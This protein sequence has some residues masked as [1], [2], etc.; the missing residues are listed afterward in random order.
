LNTNQL[1]IFEAD[2]LSNGRYTLSATVNALS[3]QPGILDYI[4]YSPSPDSTTFQNTDLKVLANDSEIKYEPGWN[5]SGSS[6]IATVT[7]LSMSFNFIGYSITWVGSYQQNFS[8]RNWGAE[9]VY[10]VDGSPPMLCLFPSG[11]SAIQGSSAI[12]SSIQE[13]ENQVY[14]EV[15]TYPPG[16]HTLE[17]QYQGNNGTTPLILDYFI[18][19]NT[20]LSSFPTPIPSKSK[21]PTIGAL[22]GVLS[23]L[24]LAVLFLCY[25]LWRQSR[26]HAIQRR[27]TTNVNDLPQASEV[28]GVPSRSDLNGESM[29]QVTTPLI[30]GGSMDQVTSPL[31]NDESVDRVTSPLN[32]G[33]GQDMD[34]RDEQDIPN[35]TLSESL[36]P[37]ILTLGRSHS[38]SDSHSH[39][40]R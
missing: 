39:T 7:N 32:I 4:L 15:L 18:V 38:Q 40:L 11:E 35:A 1:L 22:A 29:D 21:A 24:A 3:S 12:P 8:N 23:V 13:Q 26:K 14:F 34:G 17:V 28:C 36:H 5:P 16:S 37:F 33:V 27:T 30:N 6:M 20:Q 19:K 31:I 10:T 9:A 25:C 2:S